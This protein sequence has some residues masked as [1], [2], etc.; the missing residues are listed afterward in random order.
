M[1]FRT[2]QNFNDLSSSASE[3]SYFIIP[4]QLLIKK[5]VSQIE[6]YF[7]DDN[8]FKDLFLLRHIQR[9]KMGFVSIKL[10]TSLKKM[11]CL[12]C[13]W[14]VTLYALQFS[15]LL[16]LN[17]DGTK[18]R[19]K[20][21][22]PETFVNVPL[23]KTLLA[24]NVISCEESASSSI[25][26]QENFLDTLTKLFGPFGDIACIRIFRPGK[27][28]PSAVKKSTTS[29]PELLSR[30]CALVEYER[31]KSAQKAFE[32]LRH[33]QFCSPGQSI[34]VINLS[35]LKRI[36]VVIQEDSEKIEEILKPFTK[37]SNN[38][39][40]GPEDFSPRSSSTEPDSIRVSTPIVP[41]NFSS[42]PVMST[43]K[44]Y[45]SSDQYPT[46]QELIS[47]IADGMNEGEVEDWIAELHDEVA[48]EPD[49]VDEIVQ[50]L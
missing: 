37:W 46:N 30:W 49:D 28:L 24:W 31:L 2:Q 35:T 48:P 12:T 19:R 10:L 9:N 7:S 22:I 34:K 26:L 21:P 32:G 4:D 5:I 3:S 20:K 41:R 13:N 33:K 36:N 43:T 25:L 1:A 6:F 8:L 18:V 50:L 15:K 27:K 39:P 47:E 42:P 29:Y 17:E 40:E 16:E 23:N 45:N 44:P 14:R 11:R 38:L